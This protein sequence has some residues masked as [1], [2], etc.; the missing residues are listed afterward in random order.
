MVISLC[1][2][3]WVIFSGVIQAVG[4]IIQKLNV[5][6]Q[7]E[8]ASMTPIARKKLSN[9]TDIRK[10]LLQKELFSDGSDYLRRW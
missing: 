1:N 9:K 2:C 3:V 4:Y 8:K 10:N 6:V 5:C 7:K